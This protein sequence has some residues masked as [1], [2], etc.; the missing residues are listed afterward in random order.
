MT[1]TAE[2]VQLKE[3]TLQAFSAHVDVAESNMEKS[4][5]GEEPFLWSDEDEKRAKR[6]ARGEAVAELLSGARPVPV[7]DGLIHD[8]VGSVLIPGATVKQTLAVIQD[9]NNHKLIYQPEVMDSK[10]LHKRGNDFE[11]YLRLLKKKLLTVVLDTDHSVRYWPVDSTRWCCNSRT[12]RI[13]EVEHAGQPGETVRP[14]DS[15]YGFLWRLY[16]YWRF[17]ERD[18]DVTAQCRAIS[19]TRDVP[20]ALRWIVE[21]IIRNLPKEALVRTLEAT[22]RAVAEKGQ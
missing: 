13:C 17:A 6:V 2:T 11:I 22:R 21:P 10:L 8:W 16:S 12:T 9:Y 14:A 3:S 20:A 7:P 4:L 1:H 5:R 19:L 15:G 18:G